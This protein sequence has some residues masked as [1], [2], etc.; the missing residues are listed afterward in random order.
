MNLYLAF[1]RLWWDWAENSAN[2]YYKSIFVM[3][4]LAHT[5]IKIN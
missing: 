5:Y 4:K 2:H 3:Q 1:E